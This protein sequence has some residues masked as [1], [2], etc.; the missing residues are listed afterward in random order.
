MHKQEAM[1]QDDFHQ[2]L[3]WLDP[4]P[5]QAGRKYEDIRQS[6]IKIFTWR[7]CSDAEGLADEA[8]NRAA[9]KVHDV[10]DGYVGDP[11]QYFYGIARNLLFE[12]S[13][14]VK[15]QV[16]LLETGG[17]MIQTPPEEDDDDYEREYEC[18]SRCLGKLDAASR[19]LILAYYAQEKQA[20]IDT[21]RAIAE[22]IG[23]TVNYLRVK[24]HR[25]RAALEECI[26]NCLGQQP[27]REMD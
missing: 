4:D 12:Y 9:L 8:F 20:K 3:A 1:T 26:K 23:I 11:A 21:R 18:L 2:L 10:V 15:R 24:L 16:P 19:E 14:R 22:R 7:G 25:I 17:S 27:G 5:E 6:L 13:R